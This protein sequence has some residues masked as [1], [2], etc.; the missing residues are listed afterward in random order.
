[1]VGLRRDTA[2]WQNVQA[3]GTF[4]LNFLGSGQKDLATQFLKHAQADASTLAGY[5]YHT[6]L[7]GA[8]ILDDAPAYLECRVAET[9]DAGDHTLFLADIV[10]AGLQHDLPMLTLADTPWHYGG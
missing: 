3:A 10:E 6:G 1:V 8:P 2:I 5:A 4:V 7:V 9:L